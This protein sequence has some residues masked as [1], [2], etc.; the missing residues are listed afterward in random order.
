MKKL[1]VV[2]A[3][4]IGGGSGNVYATCN[5]F[6]PNTIL[7]ASAL[8]NAIASPCIT[9][10]T[11]QGASINSTPIGAVTPAAGTFTTGKFSVVAISGVAA[12]S[13]SPV[14]ASGFGTGASLIPGN[15]TATFSINVGTG[16]TATSGVLTFPAGASSGYNC[17]VDYHGSSVN[18]NTY[19][20]ASTATSVTLA[21]QTSSTGVAVAWPASTVLDVS[22]TGR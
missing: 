16:G 19:A 22:C 14:I 11:I 3:L 12:T 4:L 7:T 17:H 1:L 8:N 15:G 2:F 9:N 20:V 5:P 10:G 21:N 18:M 6:T 13:T